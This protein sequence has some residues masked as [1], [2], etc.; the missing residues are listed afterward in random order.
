MGGIQRAHRHLPPFTPP[1]TRPWL[2]MQEETQTPQR[3][4]TLQQQ[5][6]RYGSTIDQDGKNNVWAVEPK[7][8]VQTPAA[9]EGGN[10][11][12]LFGLLGAIVAAVPLLGV[13][14][15]VFENADQL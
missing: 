10:N 2:S 14:Q 11:V 3:D 9:E 7:M 8:Q 15:G 4:F 12:I 13:L 5:S 6:K 1:A